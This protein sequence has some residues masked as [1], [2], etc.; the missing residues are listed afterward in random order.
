ML[1]TGKPWHFQTSEG[2]S[3]GL[4][5]DLPHSRHSCKC[6]RTFSLLAFSGQVVTMGWTYNTAN[7][8]AP[9]IG[10]QITAVSAALTVLSLVIVCL[11]LYVR[12]GILKAPGIGMMLPVLRCVSF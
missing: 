4:L 10:E 12:F 5:R 3:L 1:N 6:R 9:T 11:R 8:D 2:F 7:P